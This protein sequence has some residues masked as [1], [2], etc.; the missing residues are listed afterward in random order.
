[1]KHRLPLRP[2][3]AQPISRRSVVL[4]GLAWPLAVPVASQAQTPAQPAA[5]LPPEVSQTLPQAKLLGSGRLTFFGMHVY[6]ARLWAGP[7]FSAASFARIPLALELE[8][9]RTLYGRL[10]AE[11]SIAE[12]KKVGEVSDAKAEAW[13]AE[14]T[15]L[16]ADVNKGDR[17]I[18]VQVPGEAAR[19]YLNGRHRGDIRDAEFVPLFFGIW[20]SPRSSEPKLRAALLGGGKTGS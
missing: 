4:A 17:L 6:D 11:R 9:A 7:E 15:R 5:G 14:M 12:M 18:G 3:M 2:P 10:I 1:M 20:L 8:Y 16:F 13:Q 19:F